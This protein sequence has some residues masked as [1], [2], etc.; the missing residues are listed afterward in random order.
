MKRE[1]FGD[2]GRAYYGLLQTARGRATVAVWVCVAG[3][4]FCAGVALWAAFLSTAHNDRLG[5][6]FVFLELGWLIALYFAERRR[7]KFS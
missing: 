1:P 3:A 5:G 2:V 6:R 7:R 4:M